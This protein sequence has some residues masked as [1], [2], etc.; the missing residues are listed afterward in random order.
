V[1]EA[2]IIEKQEKARSQLETKIVFSNEKFD[3][4]FAG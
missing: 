4:A 1:N 2:Y 3:N